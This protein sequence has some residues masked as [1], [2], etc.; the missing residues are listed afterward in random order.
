MEGE[1]LKSIKEDRKWKESACFNSVRLWRLFAL[2]LFG[3][4]RCLTYMHPRINVPES[5]IKAI[6]VSHSA[7]LVVIRISCIAPD[8]SIMFCLEGREGG[9]GRE[10]KV[11]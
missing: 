6:E 11:V 3:V 9:K 2:R 10:G 8:Y 5:S 4:S 7:A 1:T